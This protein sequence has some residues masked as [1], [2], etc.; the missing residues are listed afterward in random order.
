MILVDTFV[1]IDHLRSKNQTLISMLEAAEVATHPF[2]IGELACG[3]L[4]QRDIFLKHLGA[5][6]TLP[7]IQHAELLEFIRMHS[8]M[9]KVLGQVDMHL[10][11]TCMLTGH[12]LWSMDKRL[13]QV[14]RKLG[15]AV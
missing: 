1:W 2:V 6:P 13:A 10:L 14:A 8:L 4:R 3:N 5:L 15:C 11:A 9:G 7:E 12:T